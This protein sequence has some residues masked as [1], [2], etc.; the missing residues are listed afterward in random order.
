MRAFVSPT[1]P[2][3]MCVAA[4]MAAALVVPG[5]GLPSATPPTNVKVWGRVTHNG[6]P[7]QGGAVIFAF[8]GQ[9]TSNGAVGF[10]EEDGTYTVSPPAP[11]VQFLPGRYEIFIQPPAPHKKPKHKRSE[12]EDNDSGE[13]AIAIAAMFPVP[14]RFNSLETSQLWVNLQDEPNRVDIDLRD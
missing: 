8:G 1:A 10:I 13:K 12:E 9:L 6:I 2:R 5:C 11:D 14:K 3:L 4:I 7:L